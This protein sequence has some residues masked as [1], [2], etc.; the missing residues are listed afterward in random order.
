NLP[1]GQPDPNAT[2]FPGATALDKVTVTVAPPTDPNILRQLSYL[3]SV[4]PHTASLDGFEYRVKNAVATSNPVLLTYSNA[5]V[6]LDNE[7]NDVPEKAQAV[8]IPCEICGRIEKLHDRD[9][10]TFTAKANE[11]YILEGYADRIGSP[12]DL[13]FEVRRADNKQVLGEF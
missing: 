8:P 1:N 2:L 7:D 6:V 9:W 11:V 13:F 12:V 5:P 4:P 3:G 10:Y